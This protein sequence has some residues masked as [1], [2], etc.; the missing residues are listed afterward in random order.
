MKPTLVKGFILGFLIGWF[1]HFLS[2]DPELCTDGWKDY[3]VIQQPNG[4]FDPE[5]GEMLAFYTQL[6]T[7]GFPDALKLGYGYAVVPYPVVKACHNGI[8]VRLF[9]GKEHIDVRTSRDIPL[10]KSDEEGQAV[11]I[12]DTLQSETWD[13]VPEFLRMNINA[14]VLGYH[15]MPEEMRGYI[16]NPL[17]FAWDIMDEVRFGEEAEKMLEFHP[18]VSRILSND[19]VER[20]VFPKYMRKS[21]YY[22]HFAEL[23]EYERISQAFARVFENGMDGMVGEWFL[24]FFSSPEKIRLLREHEQARRYFNPLNMEW[25]VLRFGKKELPEEM[26]KAEQIFSMSEAEKEELVRTHNLFYKPQSPEGDCRKVQEDYWSLSFMEKFAAKIYVK[27]GKKTPLTSEKKYADQLWQ[28]W[29]L[30]LEAWLAD[31]ACQK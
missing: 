23:G 30:L 13:D 21:L 31:E 10:A 8:G 16:F 14:L 6:I 3:R 2:S 24:D 7:R 17:Y 29:R 19:F 5:R 1:I 9:I 22:P 18:A 26:K 4:F 20:Y 27:A 15:V 25:L 12:W 11:Q 28:E